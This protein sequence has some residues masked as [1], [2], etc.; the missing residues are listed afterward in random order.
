MKIFFF[1]LCLIIF[2][3]KG[4]S[5]NNNFSQT[6]PDGLERVIILEPTGKT[7]NGLPEMVVLQDT[8]TVHET[9]MNNINNS[10][11]D[12]FLELYFIAQVYLK[13]KNKLDA[14]EPA[15][16]ALTEDQG[17]FARVGFAIREGTSH[18]I[19]ENKPYVDIV[20]SVATAN[21]GRLMSF[22]QLYPHELGHVIFNLLSPEDTINNNAKSVGVHYFPIVT[23]YSTAFDEGFAIHC[24]NV[25]RVFE[26]NETIKS[27][28]FSDIDRVAKAS[29]QSIN[30]FERDLAY[31]FRLDYYR[32]SMLAWYQ[33]YENYRRYK[34]A[35]SG[36]IRYK[37]SSLQLRCIKD[38]LSYHNSGVRLN[39]SEKRNIV[40]MHSTEGAVSSFF[41]HMSKSE[42]P[43]NYLDFSFYKDF[44][45]DS[46]E[47]A[48]SPQE[49][50]SPL[51]NQFIK[52]FYVLHNY[53]V[54]NN[55]SKSQLIDFIDGYIESFPS[56][57]NRVKEIFKDALGIEYKR[58]LP[59]PLWLLVKDHSHRILVFDMFDVETVPI[60]TF[61]LNAAEIEHFLTVEGI[62]RN[63]AEKIISYRNENGF[64]TGLEQLKDIPNIRPEAID[65]IISAEFDQDYYDKVYQDFEL[66][67][68]ISKLILNPLQHLFYR[69]SFYYLIIFGIV[70]FFLIKRGN[71]TVKESAVLF[72]K[73]FFFWMLFVLAGLISVLLFNQAYFYI[74]IFSILMAIL[75]L[76]I[77]RKRKEKRLRTLLFIGVMCIAIIAS[78]I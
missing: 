12:E 77:Y 33:G 52:Y 47:E 55:S 37:N 46:G 8:S 71:P 23:D 42:L 57:K 51:Q 69:A 7:V 50:F 17:G 11:I 29:E 68:N 21:P 70:F 43:E 74:I 39:K 26:K 78:I 66:E 20:T 59:P 76:A 58:E 5:Q 49:L 44:L 16:L 24:E 73:Y 2:T 60:Y 62:T 72:V 34:Q 3:G 31:P 41:T 30:G 14:I 9:V 65:K 36:D 18:I 28:I 48:R 25:A 45:C 15:Y 61:D 75:A 56:E 27:G 54:I 40:Q 64:F 53:V 1:I 13:N 35:I 4:F 63:D 32:A 67:L 6:L 38:Q 10:I 22:T 19:K